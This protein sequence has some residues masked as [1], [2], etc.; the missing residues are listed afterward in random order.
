MHKLVG[1]FSFPF[2]AELYLAMNVGGRFGDHATLQ[3]FLALFLN[4]P[5]ADT[6][7]VRAV[8]DLLQDDLNFAQGGGIAPDNQSGTVRDQG[9]YPRV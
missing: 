5:D 4:L 3:E 9:G 1:L 8:V 7:A 2:L 6:Q